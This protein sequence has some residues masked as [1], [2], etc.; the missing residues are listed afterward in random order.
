MGKIILICFYLV[1]LFEAR[2]DWLISMNQEVNRFIIE[3][4]EPQG[5]D[6]FFAWNFFDTIL[7]SNKGYSAYVFEDLAAQFLRDNPEIRKQLAEA[8]SRDKELADNGAAQL[9]WV[10]DHS[11]WKE[12]EQN[13]YPV[14]WLE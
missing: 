7:Q 9:S 14:Y 11:S 2:A 8:K 10:Y 5:E 3:V 4:L 1:T 6:S 13:R 12:K